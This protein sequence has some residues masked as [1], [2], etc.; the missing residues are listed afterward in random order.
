MI[1]SIAIKSQSGTYNEVSW[2]KDC[3]Q[4]VE[5]RVEHILKKKVTQ[6]DTQ[7][8]EREIKESGTYDV[9]RE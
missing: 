7:R 1:I 2:T 5:Q 9:T 3:K 4:I 6:R 8:I